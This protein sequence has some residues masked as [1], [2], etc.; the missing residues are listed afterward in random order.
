M[1]RHLKNISE[2]LTLKNAYEKDGRNLLPEDLSLKK[3]CSLIHDDEKI[4]FVG[5]E[6]DI[7]SSLS[8]ENEVDCSNYVI[9]PEI[10]DSHTHLI[11]GGNRSDEYTMRLNGADYQ[12]VAKAG[13]GI[14][15]TVKATN[16]ASRLDLLNLCKERIE[17]I[18][19]YGVGSIEIKSGYGLNYETEKSLSSIIHELKKSFS[20]KIQIKNTYMAAHAVPKD[21]SSS[22]AY[23][24]KVVIPLMEELKKEDII[25]AVDIF[26]EEG[27]F[28]AA[29]TENL[30]KAASKIGLPVKS[31]A[32]EFQDNKG[33]L[34]ATKYNALSTDHLLCTGEDGIEALGKSSTIAT[35]LPGTGFFLGK[36]Q[37]NA[38]RFLKAGAKVA[39]ASD[40]NPGSCH[41]DNV[42][43]IASLIAPQYGLNTCQLWSAITLN[44]AHALGLKNQGS[45]QEGMAPRFTFFKVPSLSQITYSW[46]KNF[47]VQID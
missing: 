8:W 25:D 30:F 44:A 40:Y 11:F 10:V 14:L 41:Y 5:D 18:H 38:Q 15:S 4:L 9:T 42:L 13:G 26:H 3:H 20:P 24:N 45:L 23:I 39:I 33:A 35:L 37:A 7:P 17:R 12:E 21:F 16:A 29:D 46:G 36:S 19:S 6:K 28:T 1:K 27:Y 22:E 43:M 31:H 32:D 47:A 2:L 34:L